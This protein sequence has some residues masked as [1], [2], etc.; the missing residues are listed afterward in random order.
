MKEKRAILLTVC[1]Q[2]TYGLVSNLVSPAKPSKKTYSALKLLIG[3]HLKL[4]PLVV[5]KQFKFHQRKQKDSEMASQYFA[6]LCKWS[7]AYLL[8]SWM[9]HFVGYPQW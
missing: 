8:S 7:I 9:M 2:K 4:K 3:N 6:G 5:A 1:G